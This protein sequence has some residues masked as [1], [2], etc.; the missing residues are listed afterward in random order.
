MSEA[1][2][3]KHTKVAA[4]L[5]RHDRAKAMVSM[6]G[7]GTGK[8]KDYGEALWRK[9]VERKVMRP[10]NERK[11]APVFKVHFVCIMASSV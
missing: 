7:V 3:F 8:D 1:I 11:K 5:K 4:I 9:L 2:L 10:E 6:K